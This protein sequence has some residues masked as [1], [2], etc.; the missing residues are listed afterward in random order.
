MRRRY[1]IALRKNLVTGTSRDHAGRG[2]RTA[3][4]SQSPLWTVSGAAAR[5]QVDREVR[6]TAWFPSRPCRAMLL[7]PD[8]RQA[9]DGAAGQA[10][11][12]LTSLDLFSTFAAFRISWRDENAAHDC[13]L[14]R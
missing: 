13:I 4:S 2:F 5:T 6:S 10:M 8:Q 9:R 1:E 7:G 3:M 12:R 14:A 11:A